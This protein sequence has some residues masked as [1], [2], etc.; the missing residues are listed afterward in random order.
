MNYKIALVPKIILA[1]I[2]IAIPAFILAKKYCPFFFNAPAKNVILISMD[3]LRADRLG[4]YGY[5]K[6]TS[7]YIDEF[8]RN[9][10]LFENAFSHAPNTRLSHYSMLSSLYVLTHGVL[11][12]YERLNISSQIKLLPEILRSNGFKT[13]GFTGGGYVSDIYG[14]SKGFDT[15]TE[16]R[17]IK[18]NYGPTIDWLKNNKSS[19]FFLFF[20]S[21][22]VH[23]PYIF[24]EE[25]KELYRNPGYLE[26]NREE[27]IELV[28]ARK[29]KFFGDFYNDLTDVQKGLYTVGA[30]TGAI[31]IS[32]SGDRLKNFRE[33]RW[34]HI[35]EYENQIGFLI[36]SYDAGIRW[37]DNYLGQFFKFLKDE[38][39]WDNTLIIFTSDHG[40]E[41]MENN[42]LGH[43]NSNLFDTMLHV[44]LIIKPAANSGIKAG[45]VTAEVEVVD[46]M[47][48]ILDTMKIKFS[49][50]I[51]GKSLIG[52]MKNLQAHH[53]DAVFAT[54][55]D[56]PSRQ[57]LTMAKK[58][59]NKCIQTTTKSNVLE[60]F[61]RKAMDKTKKETPVT[62]PDKA[63]KYLSTLLTEHIKTCR[64]LFNQKYAG[65]RSN[66]EKAPKSKLRR[67]SSQ[68]KA[69]GYLQ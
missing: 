35:P 8:A 29:T 22:D 60:T 12:R 46:I 30:R 17:S 67:I 41:F 6:N 38:G 9:A 36:D 58:G 63:H 2:T 24:R 61:F 13:A 47:P 51:Q 11:H 34:R 42:L 14:F 7:P 66:Y 49:D 26:Q 27:I 57:I 31:G 21:F 44:P 59:F 18:K 20:H 23:E 45:K 68:L 65:E 28:K 69:L 50:Q 40:E 54:I 3:T 53:K 25:F 10:I 62:D 48:T 5:D 37:T 15:W 4:C 1:G 43:T 56:H 32:L 33:N 16:R 39:L 55:E 19:R 64:E 52:L